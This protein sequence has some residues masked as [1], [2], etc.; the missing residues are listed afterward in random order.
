[1]IAVSCRE[2][3]TRM[4][5]PV[6]LAR[7]VLLSLPLLLAM[8]AC[9]SPQT[10]N[11]PGGTPSASEERGTAAAPA[12]LRRGN[13]AEVDSLDPPL[14][15]L[16]E[17]AAVLRDV[18]EG[19]LRIGPGLQPAPAAAERWEVSADGLTYTFHLRPQARWSNGEPVTSDDFVASWRRLVNP[20]TGSPNAKQ[21]QAVK[22][23]LRIVSGDAAV[24]SLG[25]RAPDPRTLVVTLER[26]TPMFPFAL[27]HWSTLPTPR[28]Q[29]PVKAGGTVSNGAF[30]LT[31]WTVGTEVEVRRNPSYWNDRATRL[32]GVRYVHFADSA[33]EYTRFRAGE[34]DV[35]QNLPMMPLEELRRAQGDAVRISPSL[36][37]YYYGFNLKR[38]PFDSREVRRAVSMTVDRERLTASVTRM[39]ERPAYTWIP[40]DMPGYA[41]QAPAWAALPYPERV[42]QARELLAKAGYGPARPLRF[43]LR[44]NTGAAHEKIAIAV[45]A[46]WKE[47]LGAEVTLAAEE[48]KSLLQT[49]Q[50]G[51]AEVFRSSW[52]A[53][54][55]DPASFLEIFARSHELNLTGYASASYDAA[56]ARAAE[57]MDPATR[58]EILEG[59]ER[60]I[61]EDAPVV[62]L[63]FMVNRR[64]VS[65]RVVGWTDNPLRVVYSQD[66]QLRN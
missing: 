28:G 40:P 65:P 38:A 37:V 30:V 66:V 34:L 15:V 36:A 21:L 45:S 59:L 5:V 19:L 20:A 22:N 58:R 53:D 9:G 33:D 8:A 62:P 54:T 46:M 11:A 10:P 26:P 4:L 12:V 35:T 1:V 43:E 57:E 24:D 7:R 3:V 49:I 16:T 51:E 25:A 27:T 64:L 41:P 61:G 17:S 14:A 13:A 31:R 42:R 60:Q 56:L 18:Y 39:G 2:L 63:Y 50:R 55:P 23:A 48:F 32:D 6:A 29:P 47:A 44:H 52:A